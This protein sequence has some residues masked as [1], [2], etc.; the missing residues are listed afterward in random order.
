MTVSFERSMFFL[1]LVVYVGCLCVQ[2]VFNA[3]IWLLL[4]SSHVTLERYMTLLA[5]NLAIAPIGWEAAR[6]RT[7]VD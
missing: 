4:N 6:R 7:E 3:G 5:I 2:V 1:R